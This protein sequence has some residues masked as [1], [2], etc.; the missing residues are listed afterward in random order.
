MKIPQHLANH[1]QQYDRDNVIGLFP[2]PL[3]NT[4]LDLDDDEVS[5]LKSSPMR[6]VGNGL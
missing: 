1:I 6:D 4:T 3:F 5:Y 2:Q